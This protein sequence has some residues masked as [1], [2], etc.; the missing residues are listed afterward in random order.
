MAKKKRIWAYT[1]SLI[2]PL[3][4]YFQTLKVTINPRDRKGSAIAE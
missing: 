4:R 3:S 2:A 1:G